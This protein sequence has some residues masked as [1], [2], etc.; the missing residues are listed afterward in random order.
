M[1]EA[2]N[3]SER[4]ERVKI[5]EWMTEKFCDAYSLVQYEANL[6]EEK[7]CCLNRSI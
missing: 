5:A 7:L 4:S 6:C 2:L 3:G 1:N